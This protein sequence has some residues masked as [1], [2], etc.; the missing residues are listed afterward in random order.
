MAQIM[1]KSIS[2]KGN[3]KQAPH[4]YCK[5]GEPPALPLS[6]THKFS[7]DAD[8]ELNINEAS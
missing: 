4:F 6:I 1:L 3:V 5:K 8:A 7:T 2:S